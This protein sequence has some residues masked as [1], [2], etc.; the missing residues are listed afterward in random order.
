MIQKRIKK[1]N[2]CILKDKME[3]GLIQAG[4]FMPFFSLFLSRLNQQ[5]FVL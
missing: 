3:T 1:E 4:F 2:N 5:K